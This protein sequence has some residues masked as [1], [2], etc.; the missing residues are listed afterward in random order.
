MA[1]SKILNISVFLSERNVTLF[2][3]SGMISGET[4]F[5]ETISDKL[6]LI[7]KNAKVYSHPISKDNFIFCPE[8]LVNFENIVAFVPGEAQ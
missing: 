4:S 8:I 1:E 7:L 2:T 3:S 6:F 5:S